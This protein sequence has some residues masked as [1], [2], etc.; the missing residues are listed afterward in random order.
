MAWWILGSTFL[1]WFLICWCLFFIVF[2]VFE[3]VGEEGFLGV[4]FVSFAI[5]EL[6]HELCWGVSDFQRNGEVAEVSDIGEG[7]HIG[8][9][10]S[11]VFLCVREVDDTGGKVF[12]TFR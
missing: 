4:F 12:L 10:S 9:V 6:F 1:K 11:P 2:F 8:V 5:I 7:G 3:F